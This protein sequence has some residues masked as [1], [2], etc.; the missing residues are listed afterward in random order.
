MLAVGGT[1]LFLN[2]DNSYDSEVGWTDGGGGVSKVELKPSYQNNVQGTK[3]RS[4]PDVSFEADS[5]TGVSIVDWYDFTN[6]NTSLFEAIG[7]TSFAAPAWAG[8]IAIANQGRVAEKGTTL[9]SA[10]NPQQTQTALYSL[11][12]SDYH[13]VASGNNGGFVLD[14]ATT[15]SPAWDRRSRASWSPTWRPTRWPASSS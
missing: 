9:D 4:I 11:P 7:G 8:L 1:S 3:F 5:G 6:K 2:S 13:D 12:Y 10:G 15:P 14:P